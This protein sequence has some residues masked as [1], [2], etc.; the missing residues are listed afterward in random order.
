MKFLRIILFPLWFLARIPA[1][2]LL[3]DALWR[4]GEGSTLCGSLEIVDEW[5][6][7]KP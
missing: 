7:A 4:E 1:A 3:C 2:I 5:Y 6:W